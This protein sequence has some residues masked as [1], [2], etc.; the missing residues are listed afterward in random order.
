MEMELDGV[1]PG[2]SVGARANYWG[3]Q[4]NFIRVRILASAAA[5]H[6]A[7]LTLG[8]LQIGLSRLEPVQQNPSSP[9]NDLGAS[10]NL[11]CYNISKAM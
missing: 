3:H 1:S 6:A 2:G 10:R 9:F 11:L 7:K 8:L 4:P 5:H